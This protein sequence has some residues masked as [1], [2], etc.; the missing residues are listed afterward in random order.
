MSNYRKFWLINSQSERYDFTLKEQKTFLSDPSGLGFS[1]SLDTL[2]V[3]D[4]FIVTNNELEIPTVTGDLIFYADTE[5]AY[6]DYDDFVKF[7]RYT[8]LKLYYQPPHLLSGYY[9]NCII[10]SLEKGEYST[11]GYLSCP[12]TFSCTSIW[13]N[14]NLNYRIVTNGQ[15]LNGKYYPLKRPY[16]YG[17]SSLSD[18]TLNVDSDEEVGFT[19][20]IIGV[21]TNPLLTL[22][23]NETQYGIIKL[24]GTFD[25]V[26]VDSNDDNEDL[27]LEKD[28]IALTNPL[29]YQD[30]SIADGTSQ[31]TFVKLKI[32]ENRIAFT[33]DGVSNFEGYIRFS[34]KDKR[35]SI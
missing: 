24:D 7:I 14:S 20:E 31:I 34:W 27:Y 1:R 10:T 28:E 8:P 9:T 21:C 3:G 23:Q 16:N 4:I 15:S 35:V 25:Y 12:I 18:I 22:T 11:E 19:F 6:K 17:A 2:K 30:L 26:K 13:Y 32:G 33:C 29:I 5:K